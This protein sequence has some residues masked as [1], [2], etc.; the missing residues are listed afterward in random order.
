MRRAMASQHKLNG[1]GR[2]A[3]RMAVG[4]VISAV[5]LMLPLSAQESVRPLPQPVAP[6]PRVVAIRCGRLFDSKSGR[7]LAKQTILV[8]GDKILEVGSAAAVRIPARAEIVDLSGA[9]VLPGLIDG[10]THIFAGNISPVKTTREYRTLLALKDAQI[11][12]DAGY[13]TI[14]DLMS[15]GGGY[16]D[17]DVR[18]VINSKYFMGPRMQVSTLGLVATGEG[19]TGSPETGL[20][21]SYGVA[22]SPWEARRL[23]REQIHFGADWIKIHSTSSYHFTP[24]GKLWVNPTFTLE[25]VEAIVDEAHRHHKKVACHA[26]AGEGLKNCLQAGVDSLEHGIVLDEADVSTMVAKGIYLD[27]TAAH[28]YTAD[29]LPGDLKATG[30]KD[31]L[32]A[33]Q[34]KSARLA[35]A[36]GVKVTFG[37]GVHS[38]PGGVHA[39]GTQGKEFEYLVRYGLTPA[40]AIRA[41]TMVNAEMMG[42]E[43]QIGS[44][45]KG[46]YAD[47]VAV[48]G[49]PLQDITEMER[50]KF[51]MKGGQ[52]VRNDF[53]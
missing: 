42:W 31:S 27:L 38:F 24:D 45:E 36:R 3:W 11:D 10:H 21:P 50:I 33:E 39:H 35:I 29:Y 2:D 44:L 53:K 9:T 1:G 25:E 28:Y 17:V 20:P 48:S 43:D 23:V 18:N 15:H 19:T 26:F 14:R 49:D 4:T 34:E 41:A 22:D 16:A 40:Q 13:T 5:L 52:V 46:K 47:L 12:L 6:R 32:A 30:G 7:L 37:S 51:V 8:E